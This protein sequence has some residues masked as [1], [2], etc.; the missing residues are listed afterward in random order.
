MWYF[1]EFWINKRLEAEYWTGGS[2]EPAVRT[3]APDGEPQV[4][5]RFNFLLNRCPDRRFNFYVEPPV[6][7]A[8]KYFQISCQIHSKCT[9]FHE[10]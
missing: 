4:N 10:F 1:Y 9:N 5:R 2:A 6:Q 7:I 8:V 3:A